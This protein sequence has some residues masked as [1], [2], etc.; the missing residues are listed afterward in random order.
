M[1][2]IKLIIGSIVILSLFY[3]LLVYAEYQPSIA[4]E[5]YIKT[6][7]VNADGTSETITEGIDRI[8]TDKGVNT[9]SQSD[10][11]YKKGMQKLKFFNIM[12]IRNKDGF[13]TT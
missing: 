1:K 4:F 7:R 10:L 12:H 5:K 2:F 11:S 9:F 13:T 3:S 8:E 6:I